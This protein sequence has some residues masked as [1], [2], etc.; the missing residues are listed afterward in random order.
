MITANKIKKE[1]VDG[2][3]FITLIS[4]SDIKITQCLKLR[5]SIY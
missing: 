2:L 4:A 5:E 1:I 3:N